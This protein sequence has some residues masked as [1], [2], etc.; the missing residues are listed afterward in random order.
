[1]IVISP[2]PSWLHPPAWLVI[3]GPHLLPPPREAGGGRPRGSAR[4]LSRAPSPYHG[5]GTSQTQCLPEPPDWKVNLD[6]RH[7]ACLFSSPRDH[8]LPTRSSFSILLPPILADVQFGTCLLRTYLAAAN[9]HGALPS[10]V[11]SESLST[12]LQNNEAR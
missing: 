7:L 4:I 1:M 9:S 6:F 12:L 2:E 5:V 3:S 11:V 8:Y 10:S